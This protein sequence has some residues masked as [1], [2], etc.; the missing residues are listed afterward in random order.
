MLKSAGMEENMAVV[1]CEKGHF[2]DDE[3]YAQCPI[4][5]KGAPEES[6]TVAI[7]RQVENYA[8]QYVQHHADHQ[9]VETDKEK[10]I[11]ISSHRAEQKYTV[12]WLVCIQGTDKGRDFRLYA[13]FNRIGRGYDNDI[14]LKDMQ[15]SR[16]NHCSVI[17]EEK[18]NRFYLMPEHGNMV[19]RDKILLQQ[20][21]EITEGSVI[22][23]GESELELVVFCRGERRWG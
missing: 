18:K 7:N 20:A 17:Y 2:Y 12:G 1:K 8:A 22:Q 23:I 21:E 3:K 10:T 11:G 14:V 13:G 5:E 19:Y 4:C 9:Y 16:E 6:L 15:V